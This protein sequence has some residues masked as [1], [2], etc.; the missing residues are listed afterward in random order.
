MEWLLQYHLDS[1]QPFSVMVT[2]TV[3]VWSVAVAEGVIGRIFEHEKQFLTMYD[4][5]KAGEYPGW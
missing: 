1:E 2:R 5:Q 4:H 3:S